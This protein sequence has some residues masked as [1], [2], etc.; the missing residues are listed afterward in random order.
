[1][2]RKKKKKP[3]DL[4]S[5]TFENNEEL[6]RAVAEYAARE[7][8]FI[9]SALQ[10]EMPE[11]ERGSPNTNELRDA[12]RHEGLAQFLNVMKRIKAQLEGTIAQVEQLVANCKRPHAEGLLNS[13]NNKAATEPAPEVQAASNSDIDTEV[14]CAQVPIPLANTS[15][16]D[17][18]GAQERSTS[19]E[20][21]HE[22]KNWL[23][24]N[25]SLLVEWLEKYGKPA[26]ENLPVDPAPENLRTAIADLLDGL[27][28]PASLPSDRRQRRV[29]K[30]PDTGS[31]PFTSTEAAIMSL[32]MG[33]RPSDFGQMKTIREVLQSEGKAMYDA[34]RHRRDKAEK[35]PG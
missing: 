22:E 4:Y 23:Q 8:S 19:P 10:E 29:K 18:H 34:M 25:E 27:A 9:V 7:Y 16:S 14:G 3:V 2:G 6:D 32:L 20:L 1:M 12:N 33:N 15:V 26:L 30:G 28:L 17:K 5:K 24:R 35:K 21:K 13:E 31:R 11:G